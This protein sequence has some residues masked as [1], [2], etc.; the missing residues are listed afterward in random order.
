[1]KDDVLGDLVHKVIVYANYSRWG[2]VEES[3]GWEAP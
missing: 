3:K 1:M 2:T